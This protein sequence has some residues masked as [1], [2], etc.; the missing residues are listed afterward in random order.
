MRDYSKEIDKCP[1][2]HRTCDKT[3]C[4]NY[5]DCSYS[6]EDAVKECGAYFICEYSGSPCSGN[7]K[8][9][10]SKYKIAQL[11]SLIDETQHQL[12]LLKKILFEEEK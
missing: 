7:C 6:D 5:F 1:Y 11:E 3:N 2:R 9:Q 8:E 12:E 10:F 4:K